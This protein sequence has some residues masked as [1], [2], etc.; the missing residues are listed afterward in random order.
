LHYLW[1]F[2][3]HFDIKMSACH[4]PGMSNTAVDQLSRNRSSEFL[5]LNPHTSA[6]ITT[7]LLKLISPWRQDYVSPSFLHHFKQTI[8]ALYGPPPAKTKIT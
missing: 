7:S 8:N 5:K 6:P 4:I 3:A 2:S 1:L